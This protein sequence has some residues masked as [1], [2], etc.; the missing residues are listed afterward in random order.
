[1]VVGLIA[2]SVAVLQAQLSLGLFFFLSLFSFI[3]I[4]T[5]K[6][7]IGWSEGKMVIVPPFFA[8]QFSSPNT[9]QGEPGRG[10]LPPCWPF[11]RVWRGE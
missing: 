10:G 1:L 4:A 6:L 7:D 11:A 9:E 8:F 2:L 5:L 3:D